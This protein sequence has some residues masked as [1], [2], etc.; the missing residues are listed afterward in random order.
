MGWAQGERPDTALSPP[1]HT[2]C[3]FKLGCAKGG[4]AKFPT[5]V[6]CSTSLLL[7]SIP[8]EARPCRQ[9]DPFLTWK[10]KIQPLTDWSSKTSLVNTLEQKAIWPHESDQRN[11]G[12][13]SAF[14][15]M[16]RY[17]LLGINYDR[18]EIQL[19]GWSLVWMRTI[20]KWSVRTNLF[21]AW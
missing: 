4:T 18:L 15:W 20:K 11:I 12:N 9:A 8:L 16:T 3:Q 19:S 10:K 6:K 7:P 14:I 1:T 2:H 13:L 5:G 17:F 21:L